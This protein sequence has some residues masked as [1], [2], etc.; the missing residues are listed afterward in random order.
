MVVVV[1]N[2]FLLT[3]PGAGYNEEM[4]HEKELGWG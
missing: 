2:E 1:G 3:M 4:Y